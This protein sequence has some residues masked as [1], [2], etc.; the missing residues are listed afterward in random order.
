[1]CRSGLATS[2][3]KWLM[4]EGEIGAEWIDGL[5][6]LPPGAASFTILET[7]HLAI[8]ARIPSD[9]GSSDTNGRNSSGKT[10]NSE[11]QIQDFLGFEGNAQSLRLV[12]TLQVLAD[13]SG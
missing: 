11:Q 12:A 10:L 1:M 5:R 9:Y 3:C 7:R 13:R 4:K 8:P 2:A 6:Q